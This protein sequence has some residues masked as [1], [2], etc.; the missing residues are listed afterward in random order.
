MGLSMENSFKTD[1]PTRY[2]FS[3]NNLKSDFFLKKKNSSITL[4][5][6]EGG[7]LY[8]EESNCYS[9]NLDYLLLF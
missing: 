7:K 9:P 2:E 6:M 3:K 5:V 4:P 1:P 8:M